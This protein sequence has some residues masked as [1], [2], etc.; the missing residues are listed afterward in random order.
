ML[1]ETIKP[2]SAPAAPAAADR[3]LV[4]DQLAAAP[5]ENRRTVD[6]A[7]TLLLAAAGGE[8]SDAPALWQHAAEDRGAAIARGIGDPQ[9][10]ADIGDAGG[11]KGE[12]SAESIGKTAFSGVLVLT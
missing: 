8:P 7:R 4:A 2:R 3:R 1:K 11:W 12:L 10:G 6:Q 9:G 5:A